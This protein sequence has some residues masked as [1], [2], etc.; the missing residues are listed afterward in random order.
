MDIHRRPERTATV[1]MGRVA[2]SPKAL[3][4]TLL[5]MA[6]LSLTMS[7]AIADESPTK[8][9]LVRGHSLGYIG[10]SVAGIG[11]ADSTLMLVTIE[12]ETERTYMVHIEKGMRFE[13]S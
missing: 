10:Y 3:L 4:A 8:I 2:F 1:V 13:R 11:K 7:R 6:G 9:D 5:I 12:D